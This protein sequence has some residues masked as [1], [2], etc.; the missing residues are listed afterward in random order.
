[1]LR[2]ML[3]DVFISSENDASFFSGDGRTYILNDGSIIK[4]PLSISGVSVGLFD[5]NRIGRAQN[6]EKLAEELGDLQQKTE[7]QKSLVNTKQLVLQ[8]L[9]AALV[10][11]TVRDMEKKVAEVQQELMGVRIRQEQYLLNRK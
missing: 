9:K 4:K 2:Y 5:G 10:P 7:M 11:Q 1:L 6:L 8:N 3:N